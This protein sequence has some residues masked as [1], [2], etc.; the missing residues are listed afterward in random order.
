M[1][2]VVSGRDQRSLQQPLLRWRRQIAAQHQQIMAGTEIR[3]IKSSIG[4]TR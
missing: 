2:T 4:L 3:P 1:R